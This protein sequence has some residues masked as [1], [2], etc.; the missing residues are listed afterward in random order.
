MY[1]ICLN[2]ERARRP[3]QSKIKNEVKQTYIVRRERKESF[4]K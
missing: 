1:E 4:E 3:R 2:N